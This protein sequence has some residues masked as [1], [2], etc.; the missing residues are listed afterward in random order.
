MDGLNTG[1]L[2]ESSFESMSTRDTWGLR[3]LSDFGMGE[4]EITNVLGLVFGQRLQC[5]KGVSDYR[6]IGSDVVAAQL[7]QYGL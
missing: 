1:R 3:S 6:Q 7:R 4:L 5:S 2:K